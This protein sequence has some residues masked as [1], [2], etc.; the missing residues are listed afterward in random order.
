VAVAP[1]ALCTVLAVTAALLLGAA[2]AQ[3]TFPGR[4]GS[5]VWTEI[6][7]GGGNGSVDLVAL[8]R[9]AG[10]PRLVW[11]CDTGAPDPALACA[12]G[13]SAATSPDG[14]IAV[15]WRQD[16]YRLGAVPPRRIL[17]VFEPDGSG[18]RNVELPEA[19]Y[20]HE[21]G[22]GRRLRFLNDGVTLIG[23][24]YA[25][26][27]KPP[28]VHRLLGVD[29]SVGAQVGPDNAGSFDWSVDG[30]AVYEYKHNLHVLGADGS[31]RKLTRGSQPS[32][33]PHGRRVA[34]SRGGDLYAIGSSGG[35]PQRLT[36]R[37][38]QWPTWSPD[39]RKIAFI[40]WK[41]RKPY[42]GSAYLYV[43]N[44]RSGRAR[45]LLDQELPTDRRFA[46]P[47]DWQALP[48]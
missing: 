29:G 43:L 40:R 44:L 16:G 3:A 25:G 7:G 10:R 8:S 12:G 11:Y 27:F 22:A 34:F 46:T 33:S 2:P 19:G 17:R 9:G 38:G 15:G 26:E 6:S 28:Y 35:R 20:F 36:H 23:E 13:T 30:R 21:G 37:G 48:R 47:P 41:P 24:L 45:P 18:G 42:V 31:D 14:H 4:N 39:G 1:R 5:I 32:W